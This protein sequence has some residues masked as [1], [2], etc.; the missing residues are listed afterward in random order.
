MP[1]I[2]NGNV[3]SYQEAERMMEE[4]G[5][6]AVMIARAA[7]RNPWIFNGFTSSHDRILSIEND[8]INEKNEINEKYENLPGDYWPNEIE[9]K[10]AEKQYFEYVKLSNSKQKYVN[11]HRSNFQRLRNS[12]LSGNRSEPVGSPRTIHL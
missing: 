7:I 12:I 9:L 6:D 2:G 11:F 5:C 3:S 8:E 10:T 4:T 1:I